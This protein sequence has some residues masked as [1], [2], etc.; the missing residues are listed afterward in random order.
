MFY[1]Y[2]INY[3]YKTPDGKIMH[4]KYTQFAPDVE[5]A[6]LLFKGSFKG[7]YGVDVQI[8]KMETRFTFHEN[9]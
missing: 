1:P 2:I 4:G 5:T 6:E 8:K 7:M 3:E 9:K